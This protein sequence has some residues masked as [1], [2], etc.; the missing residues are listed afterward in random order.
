MPAS[1][2][3]FG[4]R[5]KVTSLFCRSGK[6][7]ALLPDP[8]CRSIGRG[9]TRRC[10]AFTRRRWGIAVQTISNGETLSIQ[11]TLDIT[12]AEELRRTLSDFLAGG[13]S[14]VVDLSAV[15]DCDTAGFQLLCSA[16][17]T[18]RNS[19]KPLRLRG[20]SGAI[21]DA[22]RAL[23]LS[24]EELAEGCVRGTQGEGPAGAI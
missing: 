1:P 11:G 16:C 8:Q 7:N 9:Q 19:G 6:V 23:G 13:P 21:R 3:I 10:R 5:T 18:A 15:S 17:K 12:A 14:P 24:M 20:V 2:G 4:F 22:G